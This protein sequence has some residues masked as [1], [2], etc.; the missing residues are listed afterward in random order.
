MYFGRRRNVALAAAFSPSPFGRRKPQEARRAED[1][2]QRAR[3][4]APNEHA[5]LETEAEVGLEARQGKNTS[6][7]RA[8]H[9]R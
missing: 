5:L 6:S 3:E 1:I 2:L 7:R 8:A 9:G 4:R